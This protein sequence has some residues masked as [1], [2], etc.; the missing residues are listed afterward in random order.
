MSHTSCPRTPQTSTGFALLLRTFSRIDSPFHQRLAPAASSQITGARLTVL[1]TGHFGG[2]ASSP[3]VPGEGV[4]GPALLAGAP[5]RVPTSPFFEGCLTV[6]LGLHAQSPNRLIET[7]PTQMG[8]PRLMCRVRV[9]GSLMG[10]LDAPLSEVASNTTSKDRTQCTDRKGGRSTWNEF[11]SLGALLGV[12][13]PFLASRYV[14]H[15]RGHLQEW[16][17]WGLGSLKA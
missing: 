7:T 11:S 6:E 14:I 1:L 16:R 3:E 8:I 2:S 17:A 5:A 12:P 10:S 15:T 9:S 4:S 13:L